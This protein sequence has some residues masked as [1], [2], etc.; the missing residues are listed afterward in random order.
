M[1]L[2]EW[3]AAVTKDGAAGAE[4]KPAR[5]GA[6]RK[7]AEPADE[8][9]A[10]VAKLQ[11]V[12]KL[13]HK[14]AG[15][16][17]DELE[18]IL[19]RASQETERRSREQ[20]AKTAVALDS[21]AS[22]I[23]RAEGRLSAASRTAA[24]RQDR[25]AA[26]LGDALA[27]M[28][29]RLDE[30]ER[31]LSDGDRPSIESALKAIERI[32]TQLAKAD[33]RPEG[34][35][36]HGANAAIETTLRGFE[37]RIAELTDRIAA[38]PPRGARPPADVKSAVAEIRARQAELDEAPRVPGDI[39]QSLRGDI[40]RLAGQLDTLKPGPGRSPEVAALRSDIERLQ[41]MVG[42]L[43]TRDEVN[44]LEQSLRGIAVKV[45]NARQPGDLA[46]V[47]R[48]VEELQSEVRRVADLV[49]TGVHARLSR[50]F[51]TLARKIDAAAGMGLDP[52]VV[53]S[54]AQQLLD[55]RHHLADLAE[56]QRVHQLA[57][58]VAE[59]ND[60]LAEMGRRQ[61]DSKEFERR[62]DG[63]SRKL[64]SLSDLRAQPSPD[65]AERIEAL[66][67]KLDRLGE[68]PRITFAPPAEGI[69]SLVQ[70][71]DRLDE[72]LTRVAPQPQLKPIEDM[73]RT[74]VERVDQAGRPGA[75]LE[76]LD[77]LEKQVGILA[78]RLERG[79]GDPALA[80]LERTMGDLMAQVELMR[81]GAYEAA[82]R[83]A[84]AAVADTLAA[85][86][87][88]ARDGEDEP[89]LGLIRRD[90]DELKSHRGSTDKRM[91]MTLESV[92]AALEKVVSRLGS[93]DPEAMPPEPAARPA[94][95]RPQ[96]VRVKAPMPAARA[97]EPTQ[98]A[99]TPPSLELT[100]AD[101]PIPP[102][103]EEVLLE[104]GAARPRPGAAAPAAP[105]AP[106]ANVDIKASFI[107][108]ARRA[109]QAAA[110]EAAANSKAK[111]GKAKGAASAEAQGA[112]ASL[113]ARMKGGLD[114]HRRPILLGLA[115]IVLALGA[116]QTVGGMFGGPQP[117]P[118]APPKAE[119]RIA[120]PDPA[121]APAVDPG[122]AA[123]EPIG[124]AVE[125]VQPGPL[126]PKPDEPRTTQAI[127]TQAAPPTPAAAPARPDDRALAL[128]PKADAKTAALPGGAAP[129]QPA[130]APAV[131]GAIDPRPIP[132]KI[133]NVA[134][135]GDIPAAQG[136]AGLRQAALGGDPA[137]VY[138]LAARLA[139][140]RGIARDL[141]LAA[142]LF[143]KAAAGGFVPAQ[144]RIG[145][146]YEKGLGVGRDIALAKA[147]YER[148]A[149][150]GNARAMHNL[151]VLLAEGGA[152]GKP[153][154][155][156]AAESFRKAAEHGI[157]DSQFNL[158]V[159]LARGLGVSQNLA[160]SYT[161]FSI[162]AAQ[163]DE[164]AAKKRDEVGQ[165]LSAADL[166]AAKAAAE[167][168]RPAAAPRE[169]NE[170]SSPPQGWPEPAA[171]AAPKPPAPASASR[172]AAAGKRV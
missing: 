5:K 52:E 142:K 146:H 85:L 34:A 164:D 58:Q 100:E 53:D 55:V 169:A 80:A 148:A 111:P 147:W 132:E 123:L 88:G 99:A 127:S 71:L 19:A 104:P 11:E 91:Q 18:D 63:L 31:K 70:R 108:A 167:T 106:E 125:T 87:K 114:K 37:T 162:V 72:A 154:Y 156:A 151:A 103:G 13:A 83:A 56:P 170:V 117:G 93:L 40:A 24:E 32:E 121:P 171:S 33:S 65:I 118:A 81:T 97:G 61:L 60:R 36:D 7:R 9:D 17:A 130:P 75:G 8:L 51:E 165:R 45:A 119:A 95:E 86:P 96:T 115:A 21:V 50:D 77:A 116:I 136:L 22:W 141:R 12:A 46:A 139:E 35:P 135:V 30:I 27:T 28:T 89:E 157:K 109:A 166:A 73:L 113:A 163:G 149:E 25:T 66:S 2:E 14:P 101:R 38:P 158:A 69:D 64:D 152:D 29:R 4:A 92:H 90:L 120:A 107:A 39:L 131:T 62:F 41:T 79:S 42:G 43:A 67:Q 112:K 129:F 23:E 160:R 59:L 161:W 145:N 76:S 168:F 143:E 6:K 98:A 1:S 26:V 49:A 10:A 54:L 68:K 150:K 20:A 57:T 110:A 134:A 48:P 47:A 44:A 78:R 122:A 159:L 94:G 84:K 140:G 138:E 82:E 128:P 126:E 124:K 137:A 15:I 16:A 144:Y 153:D 155:A 3:L 102:A 74:L 172:P 105:A 133:A